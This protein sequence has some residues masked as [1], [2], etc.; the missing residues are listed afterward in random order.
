MALDGKLYREAQEA[1]RQW[2][3]AEQAERA[4]NAGKRTPLENWR[5]YVAWWE[6]LMSIAPP[7]SEAQQAR[8]LADWAEYYERIQQIETWRKEHGKTA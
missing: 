2:K 3:L 7:I 4:Y 8:R 6:F 5:A 1:Y